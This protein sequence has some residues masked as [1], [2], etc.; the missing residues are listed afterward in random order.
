MN[1]KEIDEIF[2]EVNGA[3]AHRYC[4]K[5]QY[6]EFKSKRRVEPV[7]LCEVCGVRMQKKNGMFVC[8]N[9]GQTAFKR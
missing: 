3:G 6:N 9:C 4:K 2:D 7:L 8:P 1:Q 5:L